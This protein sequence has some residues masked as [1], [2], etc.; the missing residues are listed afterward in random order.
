MPFF[1]PLW[2]ATKE[3]AAKT[4]GVWI[5]KPIFAR[6]KNKEMSL[7]R[8]KTYT[9]DAVALLKQ[10]IATPS[11]SRDEKAAA[12]ILENAMREWEL[13][14]QRSGNNLWAVAGDIDTQRPTLLLNA[15]IAAPL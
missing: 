9:A 7:T 15:H 1:L 5:K 11:V 14:P 4:L 12:D 10:L 3:S 6:R 13:Y 2:A 8:E